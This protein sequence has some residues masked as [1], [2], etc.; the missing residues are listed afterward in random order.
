MATYKTTSIAANF[1]VRAFL[2]KVRE[3]HLGRNYNT[4]SGQGKKDWIR[5][6]DVFDNSCAYCGATDVQLSM[7]HLVMHNQT[8]CGLHHP[9]NIVPCCTPCNTRSRDKEK[10][11]VTWETH[12]K[13]RNSPPHVVDNRFEERFDH[14]QQHIMREKY[15]GLNA[16]ERKAISN[17]AESLY[18]SIVNEV[19]KAL[20][21]YKQN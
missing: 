11:Y 14:I 17:L 12:L 5:I 21:S 9:G 4:D 18:A 6:K 13:I 19:D 8:A 20:T 1:G 16:E 7:E 2:T 15:P 10:R 3:L